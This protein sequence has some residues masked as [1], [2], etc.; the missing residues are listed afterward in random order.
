[1]TEILE[2]LNREGITLLIVTH[3]NTMGERATR[4]IRMT[5]GAI[6]SDQ[7]HERAA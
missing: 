4:R 1:V 6:T 7:T 2:N 3:D 5:D